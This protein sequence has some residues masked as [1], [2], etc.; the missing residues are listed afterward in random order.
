MRLAMNHYSNQ[1]SNAIQAPKSPATKYAKKKVRII[2]KIRTEEGVWKF[3]SLDKVNNKYVWDG[4]EGNYFLEWWEGKKR[5]REL[6]GQTPSEAL[7]SQRRKRNEIIGELVA[8]GR[9]I[10]QT[11]KALRADDGARETPPAARL[12]RSSLES[13]LTEILI[14]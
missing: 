6:A 9:K 2:K 12:R 13:V 1:S 11:V 10:H 8:G 5:C 14:R 3:I 4:R 7:E